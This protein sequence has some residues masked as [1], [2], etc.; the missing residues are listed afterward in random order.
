VSGEPTF[1]HTGRI[2]PA[3]THCRHSAVLRCWVMS[4]GIKY[5]CCYCDEAIAKADRAAVR[6]AL[7]ALWASADGTAQEIFAHSRCAAEK[8]GSNL[9]SSVPFDA[10]AFEPD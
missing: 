4:F 8:F 1:A 7:S 10:E 6:I 3:S 5:Q 9:S 2:R